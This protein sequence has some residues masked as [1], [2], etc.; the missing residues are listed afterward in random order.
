MAKFVKLPSGKY[1]P[2]AVE[3]MLDI[4]GTDTFFPAEN[5]LKR[6]D[7]HS[8]AGRKGKIVICPKC[9]G[10]LRLYHFAF[11]GIACLHCNERIDKYEL[12]IPADPKEYE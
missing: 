6:V 2:A 3:D 7:K 8:R 5:N 9:N 12:L 4:Y 1:V 11:C 10:T